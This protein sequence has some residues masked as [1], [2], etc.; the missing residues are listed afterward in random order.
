MSPKKTYLNILLLSL[1]SS[2]FF[3]VLKAQDKSDSLY[4]AGLVYVYDQPD[5]AIEIGEKLI[6]S[7]DGKPEAQIRALLLLS[8]AYASKRNYEQSLEEALKARAEAVRLKDQ[9]LE[10]G[11]LI[12]IA[13][14]YHALGVND[15]ALQI[16][17]ESDKLFESSDKKDLL[18]MDMG[19]NYAIKG[20][21]YSNQLSCDL[22]NEYF[23]KAI[24]LYSNSD[25]NLLKRKMNMSIVSY[26]KGNCFV[27]LNQLDSAKLSYFQSKEFVS[28]YDAKT[29]Q[30]F[31]MRGLA[32]VYTLEGKY[33]VAIEEL[34]AAFELAGNVG[35]LELNTGIYRGL[36]D[37]YLAL[38]DWDN[39]QKYDRL[40]NETFQQLK[41]SERN[42][43]NNI[44]AD[45]NDQ[46]IQKE[47]ATKTK[48]RIAMLVLGLISLFIFISLIKSEL[49]FRKKFSKIKSEIRS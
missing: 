45:Y 22:A 9:V 40:Y 38:K 6:K 30:A 10:F 25:N 29:L 49:I 27:T 23:N 11:I 20:Y 19:S 35:D 2:F 37:N 4:N 42:A 21:I 8:N 31:P 3:A 48:Y 16:L 32:E 46:M 7:N 15:K 28:G 5:K 44:I 1:F 17:D 36:A 13:A 26:N 39:F 47:K 43:I 12:K 41:I 24:K 33:S 34:N 14:Q 18:L